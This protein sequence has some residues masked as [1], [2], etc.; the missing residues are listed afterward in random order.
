MKEV[1]SQEHKGMVTDSTKYLTTK[2]FI[3]GRQVTIRKIEREIIAGRPWLVLYFHELDRGLPLTRQ[4]ADD[5]SAQFG[6]HPMVEEF[7]AGEGAL[8]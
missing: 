4:L 3:G 5:I 6:K 8:H 2:D 7:F 1:I